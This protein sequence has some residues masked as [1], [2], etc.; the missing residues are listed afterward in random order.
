MAC[1]N[2]SKMDSLASKNAG[3]RTLCLIIG[4]VNVSV[5]VTIFGGLNEMTELLARISDEF[6]RR[7][8]LKFY[9]YICLPR[10]PP[11]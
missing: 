7:K 11:L 5:V 9:C 4:L 1:C 6:V 3:I 10:P 2:D 8:E